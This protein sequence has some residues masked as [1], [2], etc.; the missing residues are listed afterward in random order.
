M[1][2]LPNRLLCA[3]SGCLTV[4]PQFPKAA[5]PDW[6]VRSNLRELVH[7]HGSSHDQD[8]DQKHVDACEL[9]RRFQF[10]EDRPEL[11]LGGLI[12]SAGLSCFKNAWE[13]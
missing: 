2:G 12:V 7:H 1:I 9:C 3:D 5:H 10:G 4:E 13:T 6:S 11:Q 8:D